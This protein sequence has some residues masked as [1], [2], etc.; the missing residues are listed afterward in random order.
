MIALV[1]IGAVA[2]GRG[3][4]EALKNATVRIIRMDDLE[5]AIKNN[6][7]PR[8]FTGAVMTEDGYIFTSLEAAYNAQGEIDEKAMDNQYLIIFPRYDEKDGRVTTVCAHLGL[9]HNRSSENQLMSIKVPRTSLPAPLVVDRKVLENNDNGVVLNEAGY[10]AKAYEE[11]E[12][13]KEL[14]E[15]VLRDLSALSQKVVRDAGFA[16]GFDENSQASHAPLIAYMT[17]NVVRTSIMRVGNQVGGGTGVDHSAI[18][19]AGS[20]G[21][22]LVDQVTGHIRAMVVSVKDNAG[23][24]DHAVRSDALLVF[25]NND[26]VKLPDAS[27]TIPLWLLIGIGAVVLIA[28]VVMIVAK[29]GKAPSEKKHTRDK[30]IL[31]L[32]GEDGTQYT[33][34]S[35]D[36][37]HSVVLGRSSRAD[38]C[39]TKSSISGKHAILS[40]MGGR[41][42]VTDKNSKG[43]TYINGKKLTP[44]MPEKLHDGDVLTL[45]DYKIHVTTIS[46]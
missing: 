5:Q 16:L 13:N 26:K 30:A 11:I 35:K 45:A 43:G 12:G 6:R 1:F 4:D 8:S 18:L 23:K 15:A 17:P 40:C 25:A 21:S 31:R 41:A 29:Q 3:N 22:P 42:V 9:S 27:L 44:G 46:E 20:E 36:L 14:L 2:W 38:K 37:Q 33:L 7:L 28:L 19:G 10:P 32:R 24:T 34:S 39:F